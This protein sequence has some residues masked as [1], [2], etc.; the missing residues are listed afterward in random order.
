MQYAD[1]QVSDIK[2]AYVGGGSREWA[3]RLMMDLALEGSLSGEVR[4]Y[5]INF[6]LVSEN[7]KI[8]NLISK[9]D[10]AGGKWKYSVVQTLNEA[11]SGAD[12]V[13]LS[14]L[15]GTL[16]QMESDVHWPEK[17]GY[18]QSVGDTVGPGGILRAMRAIPIYI[19]FAEAIKKI[20]PDAWI[21]NYTNPMTICT[22][23][24][25]KIFPEI[26]AFGC[27]HEVFHVQKLLAEMV[28][29]KIGEE[30]VTRRD[31]S[32]NV[33]GLNHCTW[34][35]QASYK[36]WNLF[37]LF[38]EFIDKYR[39]TGY[40]KHLKHKW[41]DDPFGYNSLVV[42]DLYKKYGIIAAAG[43]RHLIEFFPENYLADPD[44]IESWNVSITRVEYRKQLSINHREYRQNIIN[45][46]EH[47]NL[48]LSGEEGVRQIKALVGM[49]DLVTN[50]NFPNRGQM[51]NIPQ[52]S[53]VE[54]NAFL[55]K[56]CICPVISGSLPKKINDRLLIYVN[57]QESL[58]KAAVSKDINMA[59]EVFKEDPLINTRDTDKKKLF[60][61]MVENT[62]EYLTY[63]GV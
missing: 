20:C 63:W 48:K 7:M 52:H 59:F 16:D 23:I 18:Y 55:R 35:D 19:E 34:I 6:Q 3:W 45:D 32:V 21:I 40:N 9:M 44:T 41:P 8:G 14:I 27:C 36:G 28:K 24:L 31:I 56:D 30:N 46:K 43:D 58:I 2:I 61:E 60:T 53:V 12:F 4:L 22:R 42:F 17:Y 10:D 38:E 50:L 54:T 11:L 57:Q 13:V 62:K 47:L 1:N 15:P 29:E 51:D 5:D 37:P 33:L 25:Y 26:K 39:E 49:G